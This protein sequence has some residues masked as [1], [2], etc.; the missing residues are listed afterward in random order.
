MDRLTKMTVF[1]KVAETGSFTKAARAL[2]LS[3]TIVSKHVRDL[4]EALGVR[5]LN[6][7][8]RHVSL[9]EIGNVYYE[10]C[11]DLLAQ[12]KALE[13]ITG[14]LQNDPIGV[15]RVSAPLGFGSTKIAPLLPTFAAAYPKVTIELILTD[16]YVDVVDEG[17]D[18]AITMNQPPE[19]S[20]ITR[21]LVNT[22]TLICAAP[23]YLAKFGTPARPEDL[24][25]HNC[26]ILTSAPANTP[27]IFTDTSGAVHTIKVRGNLR[28]NSTA[29]HLAAALGGQGIALQPDFLTV[30]ALEEGKLIRLLADY[31][32]PQIAFRLIFPPGR[33]YTAKLRAFTNFLTEHLSN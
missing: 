29:V 4:E 32:T 11:A 25:A 31:T 5:L 19:S 2:G 26:L 9:T 3:P 30:R 6:R 13:T 10:Q 14:S 12:V 27:W 28:S 16:R 24:T 15:L 17:F 1:A 7:T 18:I 20:Y 33:H 22:N 23:D 8:T 21:L